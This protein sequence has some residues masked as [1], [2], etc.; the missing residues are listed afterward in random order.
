METY[1]AHLVVGALVEYQEVKGGIYTIDETF[2]DLG[3]CYYNI[4][5][6]DTS[7]MH[8]IVERF[9]RV[10]GSLLTYAEM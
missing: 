10:H 2:C 1:S 8:R 6:I 9:Y 3:E 4:S 7:G 5:R